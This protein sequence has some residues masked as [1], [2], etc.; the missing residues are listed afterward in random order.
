MDLLSD[1]IWQYE[2]VRK[3]QD[4]M[5]SFVGPYKWNCI[6]VLEPF[7]PE[8]KGLHLPEAT[9]VNKTFEKEYRGMRYGKRRGFRDSETFLHFVKTDEKN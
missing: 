4:A 9:Y 7:K 8:Y 3:L 2:D 1:T 6:I 5:I